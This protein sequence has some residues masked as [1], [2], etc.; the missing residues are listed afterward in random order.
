MLDYLLKNVAYPSEDFST[1]E[2][3]SVGMKD[4]VISYL[5]KEDLPAKKTFDLEGMIV[6]P[7]F[8]DIH[9]HEEK[10]NADNPW[11]IS[12]SMLRMG[13]TTALGGNCGLIYSD[14]VAFAE[15]IDKHPSPINYMLLLGYNDIRSRYLPN[16]Y[17]PPTEEAL[18]K[19]HRDI[20]EYLDS[21][22][23][24]GLS[25]GL[26]YSP[27]ITREEV[28]QAAE[29]L[30]D[31]DLLAAHYRGDSV[32]AL[33]SIE[34][35]INV[36]RK[37]GKKVQI[38]HIGSCAAFGMMQEALDMIKK[39]K[40]EGVRIGVD[41]YPYD[42]WSSM[43][44][45][46]GL[47]DSS[48]EKWNKRFDSIRLMEEPYRGVICDE[49]LFRKVRQDY[50][51]MLVVA[52]VMNEEEVVL[53]M[54]EEDMILASDGLLNAGQGHPRAAG[55][56]PRIL[57]KYV[58]TDAKLELLDALKKM[59]WLPAQ[60]IALKNKGK[61]AIGWDADLTVFDP[62]TIIDQAN[63]LENKTEPEGIKLVFIGG[64]VAWNHEQEVNLGSFIRADERNERRKK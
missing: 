60:R 50:P 11:D 22:T 30:G 14:P 35:L 51:N 58:R 36:S 27:G 8:V 4:G 32:D 1:M 10:M 18:Q 40:D 20:R 31:D 44:G 15:F 19:I 49:K 62:E 52:S 59:T 43:I 17:D 64:E 61:I 3:S 24:T 38:S 13:V 16:K 34:E 29:L 9:M 5:G 45:I 42:A 26:T 56:F 7:G 25:F 39:A 54:Q 63:Y 21:G 37:T 55:T 2:T 48:F 23:I 53:A 41:C 12:R 47:A 57:G 6:S 46:P 33:D 28:L